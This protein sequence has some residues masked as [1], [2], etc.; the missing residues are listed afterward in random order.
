MLPLEEQKLKCCRRIFDFWFTELPKLQERS[1]KTSKRLKFQKEKACQKMRSGGGIFTQKERM[2]EGW[3]QLSF[4]KPKCA[5]T[6]Q[7]DGAQERTNLGVRPTSKF[8]QACSFSMSVAWAQVRSSSETSKL[9]FGAIGYPQKTLR[10]SRDLLEFLELLKMHFDDQSSPEG[11]YN[12][13]NV[14]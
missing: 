7:L 8:L 5:L 1:L 4:F 14:Q 6:Y 3:H 9:W 10:N 11:S 2:E 13:R 12:A